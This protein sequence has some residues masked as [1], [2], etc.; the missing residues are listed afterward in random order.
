[1]CSSAEIQKSIKTKT[2]NV[3]S[4]IL[5]R[6]RDTSPPGETE[7]LTDPADP[8]TVKQNRTAQIAAGHGD[9]IP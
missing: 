5:T 2:A 8:H 6:W 4:T 1:M 7:I 9:T 3:G